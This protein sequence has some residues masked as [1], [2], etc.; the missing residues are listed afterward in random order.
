VACR[1]EELGRAAVE[2]LGGAPCEFAP[3][4]LAS[5]ESIDAF[6]THMEKNVGRCD[7]LVNNAG[8]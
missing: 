2:A 3:L 4:D 6:A 7:G 5:N 1:N 8:K